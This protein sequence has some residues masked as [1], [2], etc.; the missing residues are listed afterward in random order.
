MGRGNANASARPCAASRSITGPPGKAEA[1]AASRPCRTPRPPRRRASRRASGT[2][3][4]PFTSTSSVCPPET[5][6]ATAGQRALAV[7]ERGR[8]QVRL[9]VVDADHRDPQRG[10]AYALANATPTTSEPTRP[11][12]CVTAIA[13]RSSGLDAGFRERALD[14]RRQQLEVRARGQLGHDAAVEPVHVLRRDQVRAQPRGRPRARATRRVV[15]RGLDAE[16]E[17][18]GVARLAS[19]RSRR[20]R[21]SCASSHAMYF[22]APAAIAHRDQLGRVVGV[23]LVQAREQRGPVLLA[24]LHQHHHLALVG[25]L[26]SPSDRASGRPAAGSRRRRG[27]LPRA[28]GRRAP[29]PLRSRTS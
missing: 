3:P 16:D 17:R 26:A 1:R 28:R 13:V 2:R 8:V 9:D 12:A 19:A 7:L 18:R 14:Q 10:A 4:R 27:A 24:G 15:A 11:G 21:A 6:S 29:R 25:D 23:Q 20:L 5:M 22:G